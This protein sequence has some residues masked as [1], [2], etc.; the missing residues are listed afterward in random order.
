MRTFEELVEQNYGNLTFGEM[1]E[2]DLDCSVCPFNQT[3]CFCNGG[4]TCYGGMPIEPMCCSFN[5]NDVLQDIYDRFVWQDY[6]QTKAEE[7]KEKQ[8]KLKEE[9]S[10]QRKRK[11]FEYRFRNGKELSQIRLIKQKIK[12]EEKIID[13]IKYLMCFTSAINS[14]NK[15]FREANQPNNQ[16]DIDEKP[17]TNQIKISQD[18]IN[19]YKLEILKYKSIIKKNEKEFKKVKYE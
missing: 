14:V 6:A 19:Q 7:E 16:P 2:Y 15:M 9:K 1:C 10:K 3:Y 5:E 13:K 17:I 11:L 8:Q 4:M 18:K 12:A